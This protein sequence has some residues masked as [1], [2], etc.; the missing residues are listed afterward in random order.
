MDAFTKWL[1]KPETKAK[2]AAW[3]DFKKQF[4]NADKT[5]FAV[6]TNADDKGNITAEVFFKEGS[7]SLQSVFGL[8]RK[9]WSPQMKTALGL[10]GVEGFPYQLSPLKTKPALPIPAVDFTEAA[11]SLAKILNEERRIYAAPNEFFVTKFHSIFQQTRLT[12]TASA[13]AKAWLGGPNMKYW[14]QQLN[15]AV[16]CAMQVCG[17]SRKIFESGLTLTPQIR[18]VSV[19]LDPQSSHSSSRSER[20]N[21]PSDKVGEIEEELKEINKTTVMIGVVGVATLLIIALR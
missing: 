8:G 20:F 7:G 19:R 12:H 2:I 16:Y 15:F 17:V 4:P 10:D 18:G 3:E 11:P 1:Q 9:Y 14:P 6:Q 21:L 13:E 5:K